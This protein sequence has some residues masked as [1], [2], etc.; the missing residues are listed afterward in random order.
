MC[1][2][3][4]IYSH[5]LITC[6]RQWSLCAESRIT[7]CLNYCLLMNYWHK[8]PLVFI[9]QPQYPKSIYSST[10]FSL[11]HKVMRGVVRLPAST[12]KESDSNEVTRCISCFS[13]LSCLI[14]G[15]SIDNVYVAII[16]GGSMIFTGTIAHL[17]WASMV[18]FCT[19]WR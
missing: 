5:I 9:L 1:S 16:R 18:R 3:F 2:L 11:N 4:S 10:F 13:T 14:F 19:Y 17:W 6:M 7:V 12:L 15:H 8:L